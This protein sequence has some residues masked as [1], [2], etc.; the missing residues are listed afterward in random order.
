M[1]ILGLKVY[2]LLVILFAVFALS[3]VVMQRRQKNFSWNEFFFWSIVWIGL[4]IVSFSR[5]YLQDI[6]NFLEIDRGVDI[7]IYGSITLA[8]YMVYRLYAIVDRQQQEITS[9]VTKIAINNSRENKKR[10]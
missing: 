8:F 7:L 6:A 5:P 4:V 9:L 3:R 2:Q 1:E 10:R